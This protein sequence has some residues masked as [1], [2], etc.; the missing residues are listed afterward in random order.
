MIR[1]LMATD[2]ITTNP[3]PQRRKRPFAY[4]SIWLAGLVLPLSACND[5]QWPQWGGPT[6]KAPLPRTQPADESGDPDA[7]PLSSLN[8]RPVVVQTVSFAILRVRASAGTFSQSEK[9]WNP[10]NEEVV[11]AGTQLLLRNNGLRVGI[12]KQSAWPQIKAALDAENVEVSQDHQV[13]QNSIPLTIELVPT[14]RDQ[15]LFLI[16]SDGTMPGAFFPQSTNALRIEYWIPGHEPTHVTMELVP[17]VHLQRPAPPAFDVSTLRN[18]MVLPPSR[19]LRELAVRLTLGPDEFVVVGPSQVANQQHL[20][21][22]LL[23]TEEIDGRK[24]ESMCY[25]TPKILSVDQPMTP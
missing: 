14:P 18:G 15:T 19:P 6:E 10:V 3:S 22:S 9:L 24:L 16:R 8:L 7:S 21:G 1:P 17:E 11:A 12:G 20:F 25:I 23:L 5:A 2:C 4:A 13:M